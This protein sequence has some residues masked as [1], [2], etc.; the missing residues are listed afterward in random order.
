METIQQQQLE[1]TIVNDDAHNFFTCEICVQ[2]VPVN[3]QFKSMETSGCLHPYC[4]G[5]VAKY[6]E[7]KV[8]EHNTSE[9]K[10]PNTNCNVLLDASLCL[11]ALPDKVF[12]KWCRVLCESVALSDASK[13]GLAYGRSYCP[14]RNCSELILNECVRISPST[15]DNNNSASK[16][17][18]SSC[19]NCKELFCFHCMVPW[20]ENHRCGRR[21]ET[22]IDIGMNDVLFMEMVKRKQLVRCP[23]CFQY[24]ERIGGCK[25]IHC[26][27]KTYFCHNCGNTRC[28]CEFHCDWRTSILLGL[29]FLLLIIILA[30]GGVWL[31]RLAQKYDW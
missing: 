2:L 6:I 10:C 30:L 29:F 28:V 20:K 21:H 17:T 1:I 9:I 27:C 13:G 14:F 7:G 24:V 8:T 18:M 5:C 4:T 16:I 15:N 26:R 12:V 19:P 11:S 25:F 31:R 3:Q 23:N 22:V